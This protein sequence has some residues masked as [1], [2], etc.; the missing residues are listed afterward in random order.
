MM[1]VKVKDLTTK[2]LRHWASIIA[3][4]KIVESESCEE[5]HVLM[6]WAANQIDAY[7]S[8]L[9]QLSTQTILDALGNKKC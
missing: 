2:D 4:Y 6:L 1:T 5:I 7:H 8:L 9:E 3:Q